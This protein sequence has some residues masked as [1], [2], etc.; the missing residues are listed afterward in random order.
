LRWRGF[1]Q[2]LL[3]AQSLAR[4]WKVAVDPFTLRRSRPTPPQVGLDENARRRN[5]GGAFAVAKGASVKGLSVLLIDDVFTTG[6]TA[7]ECAATLRRAGAHGVDVL[8]LA[9]ALPH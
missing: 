6:A 2:S 5:V 3:L 9:R 8:V 1:N 4:D 7:N